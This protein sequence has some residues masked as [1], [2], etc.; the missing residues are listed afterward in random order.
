MM[1]CHLAKYVEMIFYNL[2]SGKHDA[3]NNADIVNQQCFIRQK[4]QIN[5]CIII[6]A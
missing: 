1:T 3:I 5:V 4:V 2:K 6:H